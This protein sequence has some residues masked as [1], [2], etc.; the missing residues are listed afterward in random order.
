MHPTLL[1]LQARY[2]DDPAKKE[3]LDSFTGK[4]R[5]PPERVR[6]HD[7]LE[8][9]P[10]LEQVLNHDAVM[11][12]GSGDFY[13]STGNL[14]GFDELLDLLKTVTEVG[15]PMFAS[16]FGFQCLVEAL[17]GEVIH[18]P[19]NTEVGTYQI[20]LTDAGREDPLLSSL[21]D[22]FPAQLGRKDRANRL[23]EDVPNLAF[24]DASPDQ[25]FRIP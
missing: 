18:E 17:G 22:S 11:M 3:E 20:N 16:C 7:L 21:P 15:H 1:L 13:V 23:P 10:S 6:S 9:P 4:L 25:A 24:S 8:G 5:L 12:G 14:P 2:P 19:K